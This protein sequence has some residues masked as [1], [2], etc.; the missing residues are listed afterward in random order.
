M[1]EKIKNNIELV[2]LHIPKTAGTSFR[3][4]LKDQ[5]RRREVARL[6]IYQSGNIHL[7][8]KEFTKSSLKEKIKVI[9]GHYTYKSIH[10]R[11]DLN[12]N[13][14]FITWL[15]DPVERVIS[16]YYFLNQIIANRLKE[17]PNENL[18][19][20]MGK[21]LAE[22]V[23]YEENKNVMSK[24]LKGAELESFKFIGFQHNFEEDLN[25]LATLM[26]WKTLKNFRYNANDRKPKKIDEDMINLI[27]SNNQE[28][29]ILYNNALNF[30]LIQSVKKEKL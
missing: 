6:D 1:T 26:N 2:S 13:V 25:R 8:Q 10:E 14:E 19:N 21:S 7:N 23:E 22:F 11:L 5:Y 24:F 20:R 3:H 18:M 27:R 29:I 9:Q 4:I 16:N 17:L 30:R 12:K 15:R 28:D